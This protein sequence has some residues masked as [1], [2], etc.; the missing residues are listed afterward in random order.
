[1]IFDI[2]NDHEPPKLY[3]CKRNPVIIDA[4]VLHQTG[5]AMPVDPSKWARLNAHIGVTSTGAVVYCNDILDWIWHAQ[6]LSRRSIGVE[7]AGNYPGIEGKPGTL[8]TGGGSAAVLTAEMIAGA[9]IAAQLISDQCNENGIEIK[10]IFAHRQSKN[11]RANDPGEAIWKKI[12]KPW[13]Q[14]FDVEP[15]DSYFCGSGMRIPPQWILE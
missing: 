15:T 1:M 13:Q 2:R 5:C 12:G 7:I 6:G 8:W 14:F 4:I 9:M 3:K 11:T 10:K